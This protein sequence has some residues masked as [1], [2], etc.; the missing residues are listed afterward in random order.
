MNKKS[1]FTVLG[2][3]AIAGLALNNAVIS[4]KDHDQSE[5]SGVALE[6]AEALAADELDV[7]RIY[8][9]CRYFK[10]DKCFDKWGNTKHDQREDI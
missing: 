2:V 10:F 4:S 9:P 7:G 5:D 8:Y 3:A 1:F 6:N